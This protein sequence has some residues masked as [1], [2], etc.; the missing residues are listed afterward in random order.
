MSGAG[1]SSSDA[2]VV[3]A[4]CDDPSGFAVLFDRHARVVH[5]FVAGRAGRD[6][7]DDLVSETFMA[8]FRSRGNY[9]RR[10][11]DARPWLLGI[12][13]NVLRHHYRAEARRRRP[14]PTHAEPERTSDHAEGVAAGVDAGAEWGQVARALSLV[15]ERYRVVLLLV[16]AADLT[17]VEMARALD[18]PI[19]TIRSRLARGRRQLRELLDAEG[20]QQ[21]WSA[22]LSRLDEGGSP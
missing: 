8:A 7:V 10:Y 12:A 17:Y 9:D 6:D 13:V 15:D 1:G 20:Q 3:V 14:W 21:T 5:R 18:V 22:S 4:S 19:G 11:G 16:A 2:D